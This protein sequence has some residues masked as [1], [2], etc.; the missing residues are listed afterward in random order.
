MSKSA[1]HPTN[2]APELPVPSPA[3]A[4]ASFRLWISATHLLFRFPSVSEIERVLRPQQ[5]GRLFFPSDWLD[6]DGSVNNK[7]GRLELSHGPDFLIRQFS[8][9]VVDPAAA[10]RLMDELCF[11]LVCSFFI[12]K[13]RKVDRSALPIR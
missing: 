2:V 4:S 7:E 13:V 6:N 10:F 9:R 1:L 11:S 8:L 3:L 12:H 5:L